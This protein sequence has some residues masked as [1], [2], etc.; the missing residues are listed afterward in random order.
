MRL[1]PNIRVNAVS[2]GPTLK[3]KRQSE[4]HLK[5]NGNQYNLEK[6]DNLKNI[7]NSVKFLV[8]N[9]NLTGQ[10]INVDSGQ[11]LAWKTPDIINSRE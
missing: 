10:I 8:E 1:A 3:N 11:R 2:P 5:N 4:T 6:V 9:D 7:C